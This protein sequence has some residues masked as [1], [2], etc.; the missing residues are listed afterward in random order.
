MKNTFVIACLQTRPQPDFTSALAEAL[1]LAKEAVDQ[2]ATVLTLPEYCGGLKT[3]QAMFAPPVARQ[4]NHPVLLGL[5]EF[6]ADNNVWI[7]V[8]SLAV[9]CPLNPAEKYRNRSFVIDDKGEVRNFYDKIHLFDIQLSEHE[10]YRESARVSP[11]VQAVLTDTPFGVLG[12]SICYDLRFGDLYRTLAQAGADILMVPA[13][14]TKTTGQAHWHVLNRA[15]AIENGAFVVAPCAIGP[16][17]GGGE[18]Y[19][20]SLIVNPWGEVLGDGGEHPGIITA[21]INLDEVTA[22][23]RK[24]PALEHDRKF[25]LERH[26]KRGAA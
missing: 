19:G 1:A 4:E 14:F 15:R 26:G 24:I 5:Q 23:R 6:A 17:D 22:A 11:G 8:G 25:V 21:T 7:I 13:A 18:S 20:H 3:D 9:P 10:V 2:G 16:V 12:H